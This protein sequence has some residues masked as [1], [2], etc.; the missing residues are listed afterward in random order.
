MFL[1]RMAK[2]FFSTRGTQLIRPFTSR[3]GYR[4]LATS[5]SAMLGLFATSRALM[6]TPHAGSD[7]F[8]TRLDVSAILKTLKT[9][10]A[11]NSS[12]LLYAASLLNDSELYSKASSEMDKHLKNAPVNSFM[13][14]M[15]GR[16][17][18]AAQN[19]NKTAAV[20]KLRLQLKALLKPGVVENDRCRAWALGYLAALNDTEYQEYKDEMI[21][22]ANALTEPAD[23]LW[24]HVMNLQAAARANDEPTFKLIL[25]QMTRFTGKATVSEAL[26]QIPATDWQAWAAAMTLKSAAQIGDTQ[27]TEELNKSLPVVIQQAVSIKSMPNAMLAQITED[28]A[29]ALMQTR[30]RTL[31]CK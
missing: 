2:Q 17:L 20:E 22:A 1:R 27:L 3:A 5:S 31:S 4:V 28:E 21:K 15:F 8:R 25:R 18:L 16:E 11:Y 12:V 24:A 10:D 14:W 23:A 30:T 29:D 9:D 6:T 19:M 13:A 7:T 26:A